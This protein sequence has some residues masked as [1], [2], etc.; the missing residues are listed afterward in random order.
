[1]SESTRTRYLLEPRSDEVDLGAA[2]RPPTDIEIT[3]DG[4]SRS[5]AATDHAALSPEEAAA[6]FAHGDPTATA[7]FETFKAD[8]ELAEEGPEAIAL[9]APTLSANESVLDVIELPTLEG[10]PPR[11]LE[12]DAPERAEEP[13]FA[14]PPAPRPL[15]TAGPPNPPAYLHSI[16]PPTESHAACVQPHLL[17]SLDHAL[18]AIALGQILEVLPCQSLTP[19]VGAPPWLLGLAAHGGEQ[20]PVISLR[21]LFGLPHGN[22]LAAQRWLV[23]E[24]ADQKKHRAC[25]EVD[26]IDG[27]RRFAA[28]AT[29][30]ASPLPLQ[31]GVFL[32][33]AIEL[34]KDVVSC[35]DVERIVREAQ[36]STTNVVEGGSC[37]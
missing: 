19:S 23:V 37:E 31:A 32:L 20:I 1:M 24:T 10:D 14:L 18:C 15:E 12:L 21:R 9:A 29:A 36:A 25:L 13:E 11:N 34:Q 2:T 35:L 22:A 27:I 3:L 26:H 5:D 17:F 30:F 4:K 8:P 28:L 33:A 6:V 16:V 7:E